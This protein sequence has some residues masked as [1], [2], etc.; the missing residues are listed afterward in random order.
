[1]IGLPKELASIIEFKDGVPYLKE[2]TSE[3][4]KRTFDAFL[5]RLHK[6]TEIIDNGS[7]VV[8]TNH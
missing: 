2:G 7:S 5:A 8:I 1:M 4:Q 3:A 6:S